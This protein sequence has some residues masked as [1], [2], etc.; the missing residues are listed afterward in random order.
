MAAT[1]NYHM[2]GGWKMTEFILSQF[3]R[4]EVQNRGVGRA[5]SFWSSEAASIPGLPLG[6]R[7][8]LQSLCFLAGRSITFICLHLHITSFSGSVMVSF[9]LKRTLVLLPCSYPN[10]SVCKQGPILRSWVEPDFGWHYSTH[11][12]CQKLILQFFSKP[13]GYMHILVPFFIA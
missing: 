12:T 2:L 11:C 10:L 6:F 5:G 13:T 7:G 9:L 3:K 4:P 8:Y 1:A